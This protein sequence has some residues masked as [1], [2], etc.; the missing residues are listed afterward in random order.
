MTLLHIELVTV[1][2]FCHA[3]LLN[4]ELVNSIV[5][6]IDFVAAVLP[7]KVGRLVHTG[8]VD[9]NNRGSVR[10]SVVYTGLAGNR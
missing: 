2:K 6:L 7:T 3:W 9:F 5:E 4:T 10:I 1:L 8:E